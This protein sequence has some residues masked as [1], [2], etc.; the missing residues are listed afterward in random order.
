M[1]HFLKSVID[2]IRTS[3][4]TVIMGVSENLCLAYLVNDL[5]N[6][7]STGICRSALKAAEDLGISLVVYFVGALEADPVDTRM[8]TRLLDL[9]NPSPVDWRSAG[10]DVVKASIN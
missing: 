7:Y 8:H 2:M 10:T 5:H 4:Y 6:E 3:A 9:I 1:F